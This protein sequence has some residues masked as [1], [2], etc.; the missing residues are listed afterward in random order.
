LAQNSSELVRRYVARN[1]NTPTDVLLAMLDDEDYWVAWN[2]AQNTVAPSELLVELASRR[3]FLDKVA[4]NRRSPATLLSQLSRETDQ[5][6]REAVALNP[7]TPDIVLK[8]LAKDTEHR[9][10]WCVA[11]NTAAEAS[12]L[13]SL[14]SDSEE[15][16][17]RAVARNRNAPSSLKLALKRGFGK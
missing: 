16:V 11:R 15:S 7:V 1:E 17:R 13:E 4:A 12:L 6:V 3:L 2:L 5:Q 8:E 14:A 9:V 10:R